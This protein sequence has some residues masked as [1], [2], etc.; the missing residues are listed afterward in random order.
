MKNSICKGRRI[1]TK[2]CEAFEREIDSERIRLTKK[3]RVRER[4]RQIERER[5]RERE[6]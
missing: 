6:R 4:E 1:R 2:R 5:E 3:E